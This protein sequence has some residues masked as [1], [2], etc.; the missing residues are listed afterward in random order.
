MHD[1]PLISMYHDVVKFQ[2]KFKIPARETPGFPDDVIIGY[3]LNFIME[4]YMELKDSIA[5]KDLAETFDALIDLV[6]VILGTASIM[7]LP[8]YLGWKVVHNANMNKIRIE[9]QKAT[10]HRGFDIIKPPG[11][12]SPDLKSIL[13]G[14]GKYEDEKN[15]SD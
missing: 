12:I 3:R 7:G 10:R 9:D 11:W 1:S 5:N 2:K 4:E 6:Y 13:V 14:W 8:W 15:S